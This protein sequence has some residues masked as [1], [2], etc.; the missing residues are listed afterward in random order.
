MIKTLPPL[1]DLEHEIAQL[2]WTH[3]SMSAAAV[4]KILPRK[5]KD[6]TIRT[7]LRRLEDKGYLSHTVEHGTFIYHAT[8]SR[9][10]IAA[11]AVQSVIDRF[12]AGS[13][14]AVLVG[15]MRAALLDPKELQSIAAKMKKRL[16]PR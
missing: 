3:G 6:P 10:Q 8:E 7:V 2:I 11:K 14:E 4:R 15:M 5:L 16:K 12:C 1:G 9:E 13:I